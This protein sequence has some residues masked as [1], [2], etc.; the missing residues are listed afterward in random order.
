[1]NIFLTGKPGSGKTTLLKE[2]VED[3]D[4][5]FCGFTTPEIREDGERTGFHIEDIKTGDKGVLASVDIENG[6]SVSKYKVNL[7]ALKMFSEKVLED[8]GGGDS[9]AID[10][11]GVMELYSDNFEEM[12]DKAIDSEK[13]L[14]A[15]LHRNLVE[16]FQDK[17]KV[18]WVT[19]KSKDKIKDKVLDII[20]NSIS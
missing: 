13:L 6:P 1:M 18:I 19:R 15:T 4:E 3:L 10:E 17:G 16:R 9:I 12:L 5:E 14:I 7:E 8:M 11:I 2:I 20:D